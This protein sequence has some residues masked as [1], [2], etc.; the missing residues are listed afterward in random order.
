M[1]KRYARE[2]RRAGCER[3]VGHDASRRRRYVSR[4]MHGRISEADRALADFVV[5][6]D[7]DRSA[8]VAASRRESQVL[9]K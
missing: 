2:F 9:S 1:P 3:L 5:E 7:R 6:T 8:S 4:T